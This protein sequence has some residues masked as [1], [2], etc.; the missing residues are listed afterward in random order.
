MAF[1]IDLPANFNHCRTPNAGSTDASFVIGTHG[2]EKL[3]NFIESSDPSSKLFPSQARS[4]ASY[5]PLDARAR[6]E[7]AQAV[8]VDAALDLALHALPHDHSNAS[9]FASARAREHKDVIGC[10]MRCWFN[11]ETAVV[12]LLE[13]SERRWPRPSE[14]DVEQLTQSSSSWLFFLSSPDLSDAWTW[15]SVPKRA[16]P[17]GTV[18]VRV[19]SER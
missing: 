16:L 13:S 11:R 6:I 5:E 10:N 17:D 8:C 18:R 15:I 1:A 3:T 12:A 14:I 7:A 4:L 19:W 2:L 9:P